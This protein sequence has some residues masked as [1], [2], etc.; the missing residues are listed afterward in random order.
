M[1]AN[2]PYG[3]G[4]T[5]IEEAKAQSAAYEA[6]LQ[7]G[8]YIGVEAGSDLETS[9][10]YDSRQGFVPIPGETASVV[11]GI[12]AGPT[13]AT[14]LYRNEYLSSAKFAREMNSFSE[15]RVSQVQQ[16]LHAAGM[17]ETYAPGFMDPNTRTAMTRLL[18]T[19]NQ[20]ASTWESTLARIIKAGGIQDPDEKTRPPNVIALTNPEEIKRITRNV[21]EQLYGGTLPESTVNA[22]VTAVQAEDRRADELEYALEETGGEGVQAES[23]ESVA[24]RTIREQHPEQVLA[25]KFKDTFNQMMST[26]TNKPRYD[27][28]LIG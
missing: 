5:S 16:Q 22:I 28:R 9:G 4:P 11:G 24:E 14:P 18:G 8:I 15:G 2:D 27:E 7:S 3:A 17:L 10:F 6:G 1:A 23:P 21:A 19:A 12:Y 13:R 26:L 25:L 20:T